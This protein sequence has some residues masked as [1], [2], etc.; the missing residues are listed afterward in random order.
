MKPRLLDAL[1]HEK[2]MG[3]PTSIVTDPEELA[4]RSEP[5]PE[6]SGEV[7]SDGVWWF[8]PRYSADISAAWR[9]VERIT[10]PPRT[11]EEAE[12][13]ANIRF[14]YWWQKANLCCESSAEAARSICIGALKAIGVPAEGGK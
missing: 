6:G 8:I 3:I 2:V 4:F 11:V 1:V 14:F 10:A 13:A 5:E 9:V 7:D 12:R